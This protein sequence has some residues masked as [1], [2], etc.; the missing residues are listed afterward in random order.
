MF[1]ETKIP[2]QNLEAERAILGA[3]LIE[4][5]LIGKVIQKL[6]VEEW[7]SEIHRKIFKGIV[8]L[9]RSQERVDMV[10]LREQLRSAGDLEAGSAGYLAELV[11]SVTTTVDV[12]SH[13]R[14]V[15]DK[16]WRRQLFQFIT[17]EKI[18]KES[19][20]ILELAFKDWFQKHR[21][22]DGD[23]WSMKDTVRRTL[24][25]VEKVKAQGIE[26]STGF[27]DLDKKF[28]GFEPSKLYV[29]GARPS[30]G[31]TSFEIEVSLNLAK[32]GK[33]PLIIAAEGSDTDYVMRMLGREQSLNSQKLRTGDLTDEEWGNL[34]DVGADIAELPI[35]IRDFSS[36][37][38]AQIVESVWQYSPD[39][40]FIDYLQ[41]VSLVGVPGDSPN[42]QYGWIVKR[43]KD[44]AKDERI[45]VVILCQLS[46][47]VEERR[48]H[49]P[50]LSDLRDSG[51][52]EQDVDVAMFLY[53]P[54][55]YNK[56]KPE[57]L[58]LMIV[59]KARDGEIGTVKLHW[60][61]KFYAFHSFIE[62]MRDEEGEVNDD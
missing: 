11:G 43:L 60:D 19:P 18:E 14:I 36:P 29:L 22:V 47:K 17:W 62:G 30:M 27:S 32:E 28:G 6:G 38:L 41:L 57:H 50:K 33:K 37:R 31:K 35:V 44:L 13:I 26:I 34:V 7:Y 61:A 21:L 23:K 2:P 4:N 3:M 39:I 51:E 46:R 9:H 16:S 40:L 1:D 53:W 45:P 15:K 25:R 59:D 55:R 20:M 8:M 24:D 10:S 48:S 54:W 58:N 56:Q 12:D 49:I 42:Y 52:I 5:E